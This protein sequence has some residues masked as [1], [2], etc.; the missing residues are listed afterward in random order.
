MKPTAHPTSIVITYTDKEI[1]GF[2]VGSRTGNLVTLTAL[3]LV[4]IWLA[5][6]TAFCIT[7]KGTD[8]RL[9]KKKKN[10]KKSRRQKFEEYWGEMDES[11]NSTTAFNPSDHD[12][13]SQTFESPPPVISAPVISPPPTSSPSKDVVVNP[14]HTSASSTESFATA[15]SQ[16]EANFTS[17]V[18]EEPSF[19]ADFP[20]IQQQQE[21]EQEVKTE[22]TTSPSKSTEDSAKV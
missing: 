10:P 5:V 13:S 15:S 2:D 18:E 3:V 17:T 1:F 8:P 6:S 21:Q 4:V 14:V 16:P 20:T 7:R 19:V 11:T 22:N 12:S 9:N